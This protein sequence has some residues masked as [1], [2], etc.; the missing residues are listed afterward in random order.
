MERC[1]ND[2]GCVE[3]GGQV[4]GTCGWPY[5]ETMYKNLPLALW[6]VRKEGCVEAKGQ[7]VGS[8]V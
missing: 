3:T 6:Y 5:T 8:I 4:E 1:R 7:N 2:G